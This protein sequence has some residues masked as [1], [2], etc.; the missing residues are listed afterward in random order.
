MEY[1]INDDEID[2]YEHNVLV[3]ESEEDALY[4]CMYE[5]SQMISPMGKYDKFKKYIEK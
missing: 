1:A 5:M 4:D 2:F 3:H